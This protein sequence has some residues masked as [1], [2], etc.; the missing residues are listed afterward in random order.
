MAAKKGKK[1]GEAAVELSLRP[2][3]LKKI[4]KAFKN[5]GFSESGGVLVEF[6]RSGVMFRMVTASADQIAM[7]AI[8]AKGFSKYKCGEPT[9]TVLNHDNI[10]AMKAWADGKK[11][12]I[13]IELKLGE[14]YLTMKWG[15]LNGRTKH[16]Y[17]EDVENDV[18]QLTNSLAGAEDNLLQL[19]KLESEPFVFVIERIAKLKTD[20][21]SPDYSRVEGNG[22]KVQYFRELGDND[23]AEAE[24]KNVE[25]KGKARKDMEVA[26]FDT[27]KLQALVTGFCPFGKEVKVTGATN[28]PLI[29]SAHG[30]K[31][32]DLSKF[33]EDVEYVVA[34]APK[35]IEE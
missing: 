7:V 2:S 34:L 27:E 17:F 19:G 28:K 14:S 21:Y 25:R 30:T 3:L 24:V 1:K 20:G 16:A 31:V 13:P 23:E 5:F 26:H 8:G 35:V 29:M 6:Y 10:L 22:K 15:N 32:Q 33:S 12:S 18:N 4:A 11:E 9:K